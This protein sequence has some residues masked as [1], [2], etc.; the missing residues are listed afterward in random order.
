[1]SNK[2]NNRSE[3]CEVTRYCES[4]DFNLSTCKWD[5]KLLYLASGNGKLSVSGEECDFYA[6]EFVLLDAVNGFPIAFKG[7]QPFKLI[8][9]SLKR[10]ELTALPT[11]HYPHQLEQYESVLLHHIL[12]ALQ[13]ETVVRA[14]DYAAMVDALLVQLAILL[15]RA[16]GH[17]KSSYKSK[18]T[19][20]QLLAEDINDYLEASYDKKMDLSELSK[21]FNISK[22]QLTR[23]MKTELGTTV[24]GR[25]H[26]IRIQ[27]AAQ[28]LRETSEKMIEIAN[29]VG[30][31]DPAFFSQLFQRRMGCSPGK[32]RNL[33]MELRL[34]TGL[35]GEKVDG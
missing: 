22:R 17:S 18:A 26:E 13:R 27:Q 21:L 20:H 9:C 25:I 24:L 14:Q 16:D 7:T 34:R 33:K 10:G 12:N 28:L 11:N 19:N 1:M 6:G 5:R 31:D 32:Y 30:Y 8:C 29:R 3:R 4:N 35:L 2:R 15:S 23:I